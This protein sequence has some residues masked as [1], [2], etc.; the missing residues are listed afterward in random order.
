MKTNLELLHQTHVILSNGYYPGR[1]M[2]HTFYVAHCVC[3]MLELLENETIIVVLNKLEDSKFFL[4][5]LKEVSKDHDLLFDKVDRASF[6]VF[7][8]N[9][10]NNVKFMSLDTLSKNHLIDFGCRIDTKILFDLYHDE[11]LNSIIIDKFNLEDWYTSNI[12][13]MNK[14]L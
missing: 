10:S 11:E 2:G 8:K 14:F 1:R 5:E 4:N 7:F 12:H 6:R 13:K 3:G 9:N